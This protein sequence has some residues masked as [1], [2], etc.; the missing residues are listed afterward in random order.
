MIMNPLDDCS[1]TCFFDFRSY[2]KV[3]S[4]YVRSVVYM[5]RWQKLM[6]EMS[7]YAVCETDGETITIDQAFVGDCYGSSKLRES[8]TMIDDILG[9]IPSEHDCR[10]ASTFIHWLARNE[11]F[12]IETKYL[13]E[14]VGADSEMRE[15]IYQGYFN[16]KNQRSNMTKSGRIPLDNIVNEFRKRNDVPL[17]FY[18]F[19]DMKTIHKN[20]VHDLETINLMVRWIA[21]DR[22]QKFIEGCEHNIK[23]KY[24]RK[25]YDPNLETEFGKTSAQKWL[26]KRPTRS[27]P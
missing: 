19:D 23:I 10:I 1:E 25:N 2:N 22:G 14:S 27:L 11:S 7:N 16:K 26:S 12:L 24:N 21:S 9:G 18:D 4:T 6:L 15:I 3:D 8:L 13:C 20:T 5:K 17:F